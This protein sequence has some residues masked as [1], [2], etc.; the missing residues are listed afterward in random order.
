MVYD[1]IKLPAPVIRSFSTATVS[2]LMEAK[3]LQ[4]LR[5]SPSH[6]T[7]SKGRTDLFIMSLSFY[8][9]AKSFP[10]TL[11]AAWLFTEIITI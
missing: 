1:A 7:A 3:R 6:M 11:Q 10:E 2:A 8:R 5:M 4:Q 9:G